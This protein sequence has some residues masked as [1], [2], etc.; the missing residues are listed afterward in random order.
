M[1]TARMHCLRAQERGA[2]E[3]DTLILNFQ[4]PDLRDNKYLSFEPCLWYFILAAPA[5]GLRVLGLSQ[6]RGQAGEAE[7][8]RPCILRPGWMRPAF[9][10]PA[11]ARTWPFAGGLDTGPAFLTWSHHSSPLP[12]KDC[13]GPS[14]AA[15]T[16]LPQAR[17]AQGRAPT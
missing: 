8:G 15:T 10:F 1:K 11:L 5:P 4:P 3:A 17:P 2:G 12:P 7:L 9:L 6:V 13:P 14:R 16:P